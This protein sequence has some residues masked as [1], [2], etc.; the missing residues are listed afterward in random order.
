MKEGRG[1]RPVFFSPLPNIDHYRSAEADT[2]LRAGKDRIGEDKKEG[3]NK[4]RTE[5]REEDTKEGRHKGRKRDKGRKGRVRWNVCGR[6]S[7]KG[8]RKG[9]RKVE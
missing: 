5:Q 3:R 6:K 4:R 2:T 9:G 8:G 7:W 1:I